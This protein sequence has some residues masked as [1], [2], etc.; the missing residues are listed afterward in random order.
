MSAGAATAATATVS[1]TTVPAGQPDPVAYIPRVFT[2]AGSGP[3]GTYLY[4]KQRPA[5]GAGCA[6]TAFA[7]PGR[8]STGF[9]GLPINGSYSFQRVATWDA[10]GDWTFCIWVVPSETTIA[11]AIAQTVSFRTP[12]GHIATTI[13]PSTPHVGERAEVTLAGATEAP[14]RLWLKIRP[15]S[16]GPCAPTY[17]ADTGQ[18]LIDGWDADGEF[19]VR[20]Y[21]WPSSPGQYVL[22]TWLAGSSYDPW[23]IAGPEGETF[24]VMPLPPVVSSASALDCR[25]RSTAVRFHARRVKSICARYRFSTPPPAGARLTVSYVTPTRRT[26][27]TVTS[28]WPGNASR[29][30]TAAALPA[31]AYLNRHGRWRAILRVAGKRLKST[32]FRVV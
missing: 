10:P 21:T 6:P 18:S 30:L 13:R 3:A 4:M 20:R 32:T 19:A 22:C 17:D 2:V 1:V 9:Y 14:R 15:A 31:R 11:S 24:T 5:G 16:A 27:K 26:Y 8:L 7:D 29:V 12:P 28:R 23:P 25:K